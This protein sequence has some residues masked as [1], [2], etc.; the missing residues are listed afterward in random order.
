MYVKKPITIRDLK[1]T[2]LSYYLSVKET[3]NRCVFK[4]DLKFSS[5]DAF[6][7][8]SGNLFHKVRAVTLK[9]Q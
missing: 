4:M 9:A 2:Y 8:S 7:I 3:L 5:D 1:D 6:L